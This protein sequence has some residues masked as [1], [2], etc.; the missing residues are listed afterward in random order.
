M[1]TRSEAILKKRK[2]A[3]CLTTSIPFAQNA[4]V[5][6]ML[7]KIVPGRFGFLTYTRR[8]EQTHII[9]I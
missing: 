2:L 6:T 9:M 7:E 4:E 1:R 3:F 5:V 8:F